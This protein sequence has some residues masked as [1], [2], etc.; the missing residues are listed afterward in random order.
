[1]G[2][3]LFT[4]V[5]YSIYTENESFWVNNLIILICEF[6]NVSGKTQSKNIVTFQNTIN[7]TLIKNENKQINVL[8]IS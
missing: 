3:L 2:C 1:M 5:N 4:Q 6:T 8:I 7:L